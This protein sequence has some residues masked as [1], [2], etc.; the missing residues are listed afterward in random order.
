MDGY[1][2][3]QESNTKRNVIIGVVVAVLLLVIGIG[4]FVI[5]KRRGGEGGVTPVVNTPGAIN[6]PGGGLN[7]APPPPI[8]SPGSGGGQPDAPLAPEKVIISNDPVEVADPEAPPATT[9]DPTTNRLLTDKEKEDLGY[10]KE[11]VVRAQAFRSTAGTVYIKYIVESKPSDKDGDGL[12]DAE[13]SRL[14]TDSNKADT[15]G[16][17]LTDRQEVQ[18]YNTDPRSAD[19]D[20]DGTGDKQEVDSKTNPPPPPPEPAPAPEP[21]PAPAGPS[22]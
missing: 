8:G 13:E 3:E 15:D 18:D 4:V 21:S 6:G 10:P 12:S 2:Y 7:A 5:V 9:I 16:D 11:W 1:E 20:D 19:T 14:R 22:E 17:G